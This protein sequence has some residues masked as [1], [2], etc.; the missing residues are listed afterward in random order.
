MNTA[1]NKCDCSDD[2]RKVS[3]EEIT[4]WC[5]AKRTENPIIYMGKYN[6]MN[7]NGFYQVYYISF[8]IIIS[9]NL[10]IF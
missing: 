7:S 5:S 4:T 3:Y 10:Y 6:H 1:G 8:S 2:E 9:N